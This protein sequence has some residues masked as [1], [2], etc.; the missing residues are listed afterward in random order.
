MAILVIAIG[1]V[2]GEDAPTPSVEITELYDVI[3]A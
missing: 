3:A 1:Q 2:M